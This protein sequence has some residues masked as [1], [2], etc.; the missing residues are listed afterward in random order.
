MNVLAFDP[1]STKLGYADFD[2]GELVQP[3]QVH[4][5]RRDAYHPDGVRSAVPDRPIQAGL[6]AD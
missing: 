1:S 6:R 4:A 2:D 5:T 3:G